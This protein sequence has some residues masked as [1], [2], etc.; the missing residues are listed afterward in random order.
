MTYYYSWINSQ[1]HNERTSYHVSNATSSPPY[2]TSG[3][4]LSH[5]H[6]ISIAGGTNDVVV[7]T[8]LT[9][10]PSWFQ[11]VAATESESVTKRIA[12]MASVNPQMDT[13][14]VVTAIPNVW[15]T[16]DHLNIVWCKQFVVKVIRLLYDFTQVSTADVEVRRRVTL[17]PG[18]GEKKSHSK[19]DLVTRQAKAIEYHLKLANRGKC[20]PNYVIANKI[21]YASSSDW[22]QLTKRVD[23]FYKPKGILKAKYL[24]IPLVPSTTLLV[25]VNGDVRFDWVS[26]CNAIEGN[27]SSTINSN[28]SRTRE[29]QEGNSTWSKVSEVNTL[30]SNKYCEAGVNLSPLTH[31]MPSGLVFHQ[32]TQAFHRRI[33]LKSSDE[34]L[35]REFTHVLVSLTPTSSPVNLITERHKAASRNKR[36]IVNSL[37]ELIIRT[38]WPV[39][40]LNVPVSDESVYYNISLLG[41]EHF[42]Q[43]FVVTIETGSCYP[44]VRESGRISSLAHFHVPWSKEDAFTLIPSVKGSKTRMNIKLNIGKERQ[45]HFNSTNSSASSAP[46][47]AFYLEPD[48]AYKATLSYSITNSLGQL[49]RFYFSLLLPFMMALTIAVLAFQAVYT[50]SNYTTGP[51]ND[52]VLADSLNCD[53]NRGS[54]REEEEDAKQQQQHQQQQRQRQEQQQRQRKEKSKRESERE[55]ARNEGDEGEEEE[56]ENEEEGEEERKGKGE[57]E[58]EYEYEYEDEGISSSSAE[59]A[60]AAANKIHHEILFQESIE[61]VLGMNLLPISMLLLMPVFPFFTG[62]MVNFVLLLLSGP[63]GDI[64]NIDSNSWDE[65]LEKEESLAEYEPNDTMKLMRDLKDKFEARTFSS[66]LP[67]HILLSELHNLS[68]IQ[69]ITVLTILFTLSYIIILVLSF[70]L[71]TLI[72]AISLAYTSLESK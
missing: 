66:M 23:R 40:I 52:S 18:D 60:D 51:S 15:L 36:L 9:M 34:L 2:I 25:E 44:S 50:V 42:W 62:L 37:G 68:Y 55:K 43:T 30:L 10:F 72:K 59:A 32:R 58:D 21:V 49:I 22:L 38:L 33:L 28:S 24:L 31:I 14:F 47:I 20:Y 46:S 70:I 63:R 27:V 8:D 65:S 1:W 4:K 3:G 11:F 48:C 29:G 12:Q 57:E 53:P 69:S 6:H 41:L 61:R 17:E 39:S 67:R 13:W 26:A 64:G 7:A 56:E 71:T 35:E 19:I 16:T 54:S 45:S 5:L